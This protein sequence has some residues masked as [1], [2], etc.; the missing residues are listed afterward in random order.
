MNSF[1]TASTPRLFLAAL[2]FAAALPIAAHAQAPTTADTIRACYV[3]A[4]GTIYR[5]GVAGSPTACHGGHIEMTWNVAGP[6]GAPGAPGEKGEKG[7]KGD[8]GDTGPAGAQ[9]PAGP[10]GPVGATGPQG[11]QGIQGPAGN[12]GSLAVQLVRDSADIS[13]GRFGRATAICPTGK[14]LLGGGFQFSFFDRAST[15]IVGSVPLF[16]SG[17]PV[18]NAWSAEGFN[19][20]TNTSG[21]IRRIYAY[22]LCGGTQ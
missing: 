19:D 2:A 8:K 16:A 7:D 6:A 15:K 5:I 9:G 12:G 21:A 3:P 20:D 17:S 14:V 11:P 22:A 13:P 4:S 10:Q 18:P 1:T